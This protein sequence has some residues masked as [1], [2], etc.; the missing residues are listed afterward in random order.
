M[1]RYQYCPWYVK[2]WRSRWHLLRP[3]WAI[4][5]YW[6]S[7]KR[8]TTLSNAWSYAHGWAHYHMEW[9]YTHDEVRE[10]MKDKFR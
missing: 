3:F 10:H 4:K 7:D 8:S 5:F 2:L 6:H 1:K 9:W